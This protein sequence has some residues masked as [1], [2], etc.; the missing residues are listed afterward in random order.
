M[1]AT[2]GGII[3]IFKVKGYGAQK[4]RPD[5]PHF[6]E[7]GSNEVDSE[8]DRVV[9]LPLNDNMAAVA[10]RRASGFNMQLPPQRKTSGSGQ[11]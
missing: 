2:N 9:H 1:N 5:H 8:G 4:L 11:R 10:A 6:L 3:N 7:N